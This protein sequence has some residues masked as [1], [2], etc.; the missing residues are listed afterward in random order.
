MSIS[1]AI[2][3]HVVTVDAQDLYLALSLKLRVVD[4]TRHLTRKLYVEHC[5]TV[6]GHHV[7]KSLHR[8]IL[9]VTDPK[10][11]VDHKDGDGLNNTRDNLR[12]CDHGEN[13]RNAIAHADASIGL[14]GVTKRGKKWQAQIQAHGVRRYLGCF[15]SPTAAHEAY[16]KAATEL[17]GEFARAQ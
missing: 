17:H 16:S 4:K 2:G 1:F 3:P 13:A 9:G 11:L 10:I 12:V 14:R 15:T 6:A 8:L 7:H 5:A